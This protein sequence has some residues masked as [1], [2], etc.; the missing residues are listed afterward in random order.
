ME[1]VSA[2]G[3]TESKAFV[4]PTPFLL[5]SCPGNGEL[6]SGS[7]CCCRSPHRRTPEDLREADG[8][9]GDAELVIRPATQDQGA[10]ERK[11]QGSRDAAGL[12]DS[13][14]VDPLVMVWF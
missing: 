5:E 8:K 4:C 7:C 1:A 10:S 3:W 6:S 13:D 2:A 14:D 12:D 11:H 9:S